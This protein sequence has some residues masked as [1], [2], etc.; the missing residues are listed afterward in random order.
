M[1][2]LSIDT[3][4]DT[5]LSWVTFAQ[6]EPTEPCDCTDGEIQ[7][8]HE[9]I[10]RVIL[11]RGECTCGKDNCLVCLKHKDILVDATRKSGP[12]L[13]C[14]ECHVPIMVVRFDPIHA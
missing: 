7:C 13:M 8:P 14:S 9:P 4:E 12:D 3:I 5:D 10:A 2:R 1:A 11:D 6:E